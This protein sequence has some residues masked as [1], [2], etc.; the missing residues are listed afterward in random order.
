[1][2]ATQTRRRPSSGAGS[3]RLRR[4]GAADSRFNADPDESPGAMSEKDRQEKM[5]GGRREK[6]KEAIGIG[7]R[8]YLSCEIGASS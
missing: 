3:F 1:M 7:A 2:S 6:R 5:T 4:R 8:L